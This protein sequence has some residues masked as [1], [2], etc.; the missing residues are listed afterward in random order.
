MISNKG[1][2][3]YN[4]LNQ[5][6]ILDIHYMSEKDICLLEEELKGLLSEKR[7]KVTTLYF[8]DKMSA[9]QIRVAIGINSIA[10]ISEL[11]RDSVRRLSMEKAKNTIYK[12]V[13]NMAIDI[14]TE[15]DISA[16]DIP[17]NVYHAL[18]RAGID[19]I[20]EY[21]DRAASSKWNIRGIGEAYKEL[22]ESQLRDLGLL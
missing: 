7:Y 6:G 10:T 3:P 5:I 17:M 20:G 9:S 2:Y 12:N 22:I 13:F 15:S 16:L 1:E 14:T 8:K 4:L 19:T 18:K 11:I 21:I